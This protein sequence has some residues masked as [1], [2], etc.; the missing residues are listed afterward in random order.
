MLRIVLAE[1]G[2]VAGTHYDTTRPV[3]ER[4][5]GQIGFQT[6]IGDNGASEERDG[7]STA[8]GVYL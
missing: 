8:G 6:A 3:E 4:L 5:N 2:I 1:K 7:D